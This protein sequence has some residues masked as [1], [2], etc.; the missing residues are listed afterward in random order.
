MPLAKLCDVTGMRSI[1]RH[2]GWAKHPHHTHVLIHSA[3]RAQV[4]YKVARRITKWV[5][6]RATLRVY[7]SALT[8]IKVSPKRRG[9]LQRPKDNVNSEQ[10]RQVDPI[11]QRR[12]QKHAQ[13]HWINVLSS[14]FEDFRSKLKNQKK[15]FNFWNSLCC[16]LFCQIVSKAK[17]SILYFFFWYFTFEDNR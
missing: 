6:I 7:A 12:N 9:V 13:H 5:T 3:M 1:E 10:C 8:V 14:L 4:P 16:K 15:L 11:K 2:W 17:S